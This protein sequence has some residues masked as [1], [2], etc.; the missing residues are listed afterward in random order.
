MPM[1]SYR[2]G[3]DPDGSILIAAN[4]VGKM[5]WTERFQRP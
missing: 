2:K 3:T 5:P 4:L 1:D